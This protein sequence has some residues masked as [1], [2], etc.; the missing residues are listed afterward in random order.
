M[1]TAIALWQQLLVLFILIV[2]KGSF[3]EQNPLPTPP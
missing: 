3:T 2:N 1:L